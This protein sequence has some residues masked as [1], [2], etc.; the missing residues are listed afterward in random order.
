METITFEY[1]REK[2]EDFQ[3][4]VIKIEK[5]FF[6]KYI[7]FSIDQGELIKNCIFEKT[8]YDLKKVYK[9][10]TTHFKNF[11]ICDNHADNLVKIIAFAKE[12]W[13]NHHF[14]VLEFLYAFIFKTINYTKLIRPPSVKDSSLTFPHLMNDSKENPHQIE[15][16]NS[17]IG[18]SHKNSGSSFNYSKSDM[19]SPDNFM[20]EKT[21]SR[22][23]ILSN[24]IEPQVKEKTS[25]LDISP[26]IQKP[27]LSSTRLILNSS[28]SFDYSSKVCQIFRNLFVYHNNE[29]ST[30]Y[31]RLI[32]NEKNLLS[33]TINRNKSAGFNVKFKLSSNK[34]QNSRYA[35]FKD[36]I[37]YLF[38]RERDFLSD[39]NAYSE[40]MVLLKIDYIRY[41]EISENENKII[42]NNKGNMTNYE[43]II[44]KSDTMTFLFSLCVELIR[45]DSN[46]IQMEQL[47]DPLNNLGEISLKFE[48]KNDPSQSIVDPEMKIVNLS[49]S[50]MSIRISNFEKPKTLYLTIVNVFDLAVVKSGRETS[51]IEILKIFDLG[52][53]KSMQVSGIHLYQISVCRLSDYANAFQSPIIE[54]YHESTLQAKSFKKSYAELQRATFRVKSFITIFDRF[55]DILDDFLYFKFPLFT[56]FM[57]I[58]AAIITILFGASTFFLVLFFG[59]IL[60]NHPNI[61]PVIEQKFQEIFFSPHRLNKYFIKNQFKSGKTIKKEFYMNSDNINESIEDNQGLSEKLKLAV[62]FSSKI[63]YLLHMF[64]D[65]FDKFKNLFGWKSKRKTELFL[66]ISILAVVAIR[67]LGLDLAFLLY[68][69]GEFQYGYFYYKRMLKWNEKVLTF[70]IRYFVID[71]L[72]YSDLSCCHEFFNKYE[73]DEIVIANFAK[74]F[75]EFIELHLDIKTPEQLWRENFKFA[76]IFEILR[77]SNRRIILPFYEEKRKPKSSIL[78]VFFLFSTPSDYYYYN[79]RK[80]EKAN[81]P[82]KLSK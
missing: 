17:F 56:H 76:K 66:F 52:F 13:R 2:F 22:L 24:N 53:N 49:L 34:G 35:H 12:E 73:S 42:L 82:K 44:S 7:M 54:N 57:M 33:L 74:K 23:D 19:K 8:T 81:S 59:I 30:N 26:S 50:Y 28:N 67:L 68:L 40:L 3:L 14:L 4:D 58:S 32:L 71:V 72:E 41:F 25:D 75:S 11:P 64:V 45:K 77:F 61:N 60:Y 37:L 51:I 65:A 38:E 29:Y 79:L 6:T 69:A 62:D 15:G 47:P 48:V 55:M 31:P 70:L 36:K 27:V 20:I 46:V 21:S 18:T 9:S 39:K 5:S 78:F 43:F 16:E 80:L 10:I 1:F 63:P